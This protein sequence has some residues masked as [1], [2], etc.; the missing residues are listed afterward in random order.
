MELVSLHRSRG[1]A[2]NTASPDTTTLEAI[3]RLRDLLAEDPHD[4][5]ALGRLGDAQLA[6]HDPDGALVT[7]T[8]AIELAPE[9]ALAHR[10]ASIACSRRGRHRE[11]IAYAEEATRLAP[12]D[13]RGFVVL[14]RALLRAKRDLE[15]ARHVAIRA[16]VTAP[17]AAEPHLVFGMVSAAEGEHAA[18]EAAFRR[19]QQLDPSNMSARNELARLELRRVVQAG[20]GAPIGGGALVAGPVKAAPRIAAARRN[21]DEVR[22]ALQLRA[23]PRRVLA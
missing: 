6:D 5:D 7:A 18:A 22:R 8:T 12:T 16:I 21:L 2:V 20:A 17:E 3:E 1:A 13:E 14:A 11:A 10:Q 9:Q 4:L 15:R 23:R 19:A